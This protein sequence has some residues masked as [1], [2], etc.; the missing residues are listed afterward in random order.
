M[1][2]QIVARCC[3]LLIVLS[4]L[5]LGLTLTRIAT[6]SDLTYGTDLVRL[7]NLGVSKSEQAIQQLE[8]LEAQLAANKASG[9]LDELLVVLIPLYIDAGEKEKAKAAIANL[10]KEATLRHD[11]FAR[12]MAAVFQASML[13]DEGQ[14]GDALAIVE[15]TLTTAKQV[16]DKRLTYQ[17]HALA[18]ELYSQV[19]NFQNALEH[20]LTALDAVGSADDWHSEY[21]QAKSLDNISRLY[22]RLKNPK[23]ALEY[24]ARAE[25]LAKKIG[26]DSLMAAIAT[27]RGYAYAD[28]Q[29]YESAIVAYT[30][31]LTMSRRVGDTRDEIRALNNLADAAMNLSN[32]S[33]CVSY[34]KQSA[35]VA[36]KNQK[37][38][39][40]AIAL[41]NLGICH[42]ALG[43]VKQGTKEI[44]QGL[45]F[46][47]DSTSNTQ[48]E[49]MLEDVS[50]AYKKAGMYKEALNALEEQQKLSTDL[51]HAERD[52]AVLELQV[53][54]DVNQRQKE[55]GA[56]EQKNHLQDVEIQNKN[57]QRVI[58]IL[59]ILVAIAIA[60][61]TFFLY[62]RV[63][64]SNQRLR[65]SNQQLQHKSTHDPLTGLLNRRAFEDIL[66]NQYISN[67]STADQSN[68][69]H[70][71]LILLD[72]D[73]FKHINDQHGHAVG[74]LVLVELGRRLQS[75]LREKDKLIR[76]GGEEFV[77]YLHGIPTERIPLA[78]GR[79]L[80]VIG[81][82]P[83]EHEGNLIKVTI[84]SGYI[85][86][87]LAGEFG[88]ELSWEKATQLCDDA[89][90]MA[91]NAG[92]NQA[93][94]IQ[95]V[96]GD[97]EQVVD[98]AEI[99]LHRAIKMGIV[100]TEHIAGPKAPDRQN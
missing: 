97:Q 28:Q 24:N 54:F 85:Q 1:E 2:K 96:Q 40:E 91:K 19:G 93:I 65:K 12:S 48:L 58:A 95:L 11:Q 52:R 9:N 21:L 69:L 87:P 81:A 57:L 98:L 32:Y 45:D 30:A 80:E 70:S 23:T 61:T 13:H 88:A 37:F 46:L 39:Y 26:A 100:V 22:L 74:D 14:L 44:N 38:D 67:Q 53:R 66:K 36:H 5:G 71:I 42:M 76:W 34:A 60:A 8:L 33:E 75:I 6:A 82:T 59:A 41:G 62:R 55:I 56:L 35:D 29:R 72:I 17:A 16:N 31:G 20:Q 51:F 49:L 73:H 47:R 78:I 15:Q 77:I 92:R 3:K 50:S 84:S 25:E 43:E 10:S 63:R 89:L 27:N 94:G 83:F 18:G 79:S 90:Y 99:D 64:N 7:Q 68:P 86:M 4:M